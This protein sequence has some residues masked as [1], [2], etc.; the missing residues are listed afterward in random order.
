MRCLLLWICLP[1]LSLSS[2]SQS[3]QLDSLKVIQ[4]RASDTDSEIPF[5]LAKHFAFYNPTAVARNTLVVHLVGS[6]DNPLNTIKYPS[7]AAN[8]GF[9]VVSL[10][11]KNGI[12]SQGAC[13]NSTDSNCYSN[14]RKEIIEGVDVSDE[15][16]VDS[17]NSIQNRLHKLLL[18]LQNEHPNQ[19]WEQFIK[20]DIVY[21]SK[22]IVSGHSQGGG[23]AAYLGQSKLLKRIIM[24]SSPNDWSN[25]FGSPAHWL[26]DPKTTPIQRY[27]GF[28]NLNDDV[29]DFSHQYQIWQNIGLTS[30]QDTIFIG[31]STFKSSGSSILYTD[32]DMPGTSVNHNATVRDSDTPLNNDNTPI[33]SD[34]WLY[35]LGIN[36]SSYYQERQLHKLLTYPN[37]ATKSIHLD[38]NDYVDIHLY[39]SVGVEVQLD[40]LNGS[41]LD[42]TNLKNG[43]YYGVVKK[44]ENIYTFTFIKL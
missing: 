18:F 17:T 14:F 38:I 33:Y 24:F 23:H 29:V 32:Y 19:N 34:V 39:N 30:L 16:D 3:V 27:Y 31:D 22:V 6:F 40:M 8:N 26:D 9:H 15:V 36:K 5:E 11:Y 35:L 44:S 20:S 4:V 13:K 12:S 10:K 28:N 7:L 41:R 42:I 2:Y 25:H 1:F 43:R 21:W 37:P